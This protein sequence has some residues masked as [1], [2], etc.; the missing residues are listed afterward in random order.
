M[1]PQMQ[2]PCISGPYIKVKR[3]TQQHRSRF[4]GLQCPP[5]CGRALLLLLR[6]RAMSRESGLG[7]RMKRGP[8]TRRL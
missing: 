5:G 4:R 7:T 2:Q 3:Q 6:Q 8:R 1:I